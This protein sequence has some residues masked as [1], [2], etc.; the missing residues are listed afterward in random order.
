MRRR[1]PSSSVRQSVYRQ[2]F[3]RCAFCWR[4]LR[5]HG[6]HVDHRW[7]LSKGGTNRRGNLQPLCAPCNLKKG[8]RIPPILWVRWISMAVIPLWLV[9][10]LPSV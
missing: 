8:D 2:N 9:V 3:G 7:P 1:V 5:R 4:S 6:F 10:T